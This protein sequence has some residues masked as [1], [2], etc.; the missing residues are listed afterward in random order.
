MS[1]T[2]L[3]LFYVLYDGRRSVGEETRRVLY[4]R[5]SLCSAPEMEIYLCM[6]L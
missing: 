4:V 1:R 6:F 2:L 5:V 3:P